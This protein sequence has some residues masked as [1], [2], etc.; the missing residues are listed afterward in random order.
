V[1][2]FKEGLLWRSEE[3]SSFLIGVTQDALDFAGTIQGL[4]LSELGDEFEEGDWIGEVNGKN[5][6]VEITAPFALRI[7][8]C[9]TELLQQPT[10]IEDDPT[11]DAWIVRVERMSDG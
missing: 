9:N 2:E 7:V 5:G 4:D 6:L 1:I 11:G 3:D 10:L 8:E